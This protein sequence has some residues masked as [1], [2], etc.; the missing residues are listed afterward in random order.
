MMDTLKTAFMSGSS[1]HGNTRRASIDCSCDA[2]RNLQTDRLF[3]RRQRPREVHPRPPE[4]SQPSLTE[5]NELTTSK[6][7]L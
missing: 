3:V 1:K 7:Y 5:Y 2:D 6:T 4:L